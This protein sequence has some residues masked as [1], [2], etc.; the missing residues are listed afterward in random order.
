MSSSVNDLTVD[1]LRLRDRDFEN[2]NR[3]VRRAGFQPVKPILKKPT[4]EIDA[5]FHIPLHALSTF[6]F[7][8]SIF[9][10]LK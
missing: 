10:V 2:H 7:A 1:R 5:S 3:T 9:C 4:F 8:D 6:S